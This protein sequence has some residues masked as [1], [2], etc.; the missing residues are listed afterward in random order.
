MVR[1]H[2]LRA[3]AGLGGLAAVVV[4]SALVAA[5]AVSEGVDESRETPAAANVTQITAEATFSPAV[6]LFGDT[7]TAHVDVV[8]DKA[9]VDPDSVRLAAEFAPFEIVG[10]LQR[11]RRD[12]ERSAHL[13]LSLVLRCLSG[14]CVPS[15]QSARYN[16]EPA[17]ISFTAP[18]E[19]DVAGSS[20]EVPLPSV[21]LYSRFTALGAGAAQGQGEG[22]QPW[23][24]DLRSL[25]S[26]SY[27]IAPGVVIVLL[28]AGAAL[29]AIAAFAV[30]Y[31]AWPRRVPAAPP[32]PEP[33]PPPEPLS[34]LEQA[35]ILLEQS[36]R[37][38]GAA[39]QRRA[40]ELVAEE[41]ELADWGDR[42][43]ARTARALAWSQGIPPAA[44]TARLAARVRTAL[45]R[46]AEVDEEGA[47]A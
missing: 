35:L 43:L 19:Q 33:E 25:P 37:A 6:A 26:V 1:A 10:R 47:H 27:R 21:R 28:L 3:L 36:I 41:L 12:S 16:F 23:R 29:A 22:F 14:S 2:R 34:A 11:R 45:P 46:P 44:E 39:D 13:R 42:D 30:G 31:V 18:D 9:R 15:G 40:L 4:A 38:D 8:V 32:E 24:A 17:R 20:I 7:V 5:F